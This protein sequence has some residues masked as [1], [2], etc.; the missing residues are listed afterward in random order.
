MYPSLGLECQ[1]YESIMSTMSIL[2]ETV[3]ALREDAGCDTCI[4]FS[5]GCCDLNSIESNEF[6]A[7]DF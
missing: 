5:N 6:N 7:S 2:P 3:K 4:H 1:N